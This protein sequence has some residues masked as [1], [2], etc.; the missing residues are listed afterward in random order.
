MITSFLRPFFFFPERVATVDGL[1]N[2]SE[3]PLPPLPFLLFRLQEEA[4]PGVPI[5][6]LDLTAPGSMV[7]GTIL[8]LVDRLSAPFPS[9]FFSFRRKRKAPL[10][11]LSPTRPEVVHPFFHAPERWLVQRPRCPAFPPGGV[12][13]EYRVPISE[14]S[15]PSFRPFFCLFFSL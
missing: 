10:A 14:L 8:F 9:F 11:L 4:S 12:N 6:F 3:T 2:G 1:F 13:G 7:V 15:G 5:F